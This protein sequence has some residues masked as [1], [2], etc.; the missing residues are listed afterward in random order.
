MVRLNFTNT[1]LLIGCIG[2]LITPRRNIYFFP[3]QVLP[4]SISHVYYYYFRRFIGS[5]PPGQQ[6]INHYLYTSLS[7]V[8]Q[9]SLLH[10][11]IWLTV[12]QVEALSENAIKSLFL[13]YPKAGCILLNFPPFKVLHMAYVFSLMSCVRVL[14]FF[15]PNRF[16]ALNHEKVFRVMLGGGLV[17]TVFETMRRQ[18]T[19]GVNCLQ[20]IP[21]LISS[22][23]FQPDEIPF[24]TTRTSNPSL[25]FFLILTCVN[26][27]IPSLHTSFKQVIHCV[28]CKPQVNQP[29]Q[30]FHASSQSLKQTVA[31]K[32]IKVA[33]FGG[34]IS[35]ACLL[36]LCAA[37][38]QLDDK[39]WSYRIGM[40][41]LA[42]LIVVLMPVYWLENMEEAHESMVRH[43]QHFFSPCFGR[44]DAVRSRLKRFFP[45]NRISAFADISELEET[46]PLPRRASTESSANPPIW[47]ISERGHKFNSMSQTLEF[48]SG[49]LLSA[50]QFPITDEVPGTN[51]VPDNNQVP[52]TIQVTSTNQVPSIN[53][54][55]STNQVRTADIV[56]SIIQ[57][58]YTNQFPSTNKVPSINH[59]PSTTQVQ[60]TNQVPTANQVPIINQVSSTNQASAAN[61]ARIFN[62]GSSI[63]QVS[64][65]NKVLTANQVPSITQVPSTNQ[66]LTANQVPSIYQ[67]QSAYQVQSTYLTPVQTD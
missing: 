36:A 41:R 10:A 67:V 32:L 66:V 38:F 51:Q 8:G 14:L 56:L 40:L 53:Q 22:L 6:T 20:F 23:G 30:G 28:F 29:N 7:F 21:Y 61:Q 35:A 33:T 64:A 48:S 49:R 26:F 50:N 63:T 19:S 27:S 9:A 58:P 57:V 11:Q 65:A 60:S 13:A 3:V 34:C 52:G 39:V 18:L 15:S 42:H 17:L 55:P 62:Q 46:T 1:I 2:F 5:R 45:T 25:T 31:K 12:S 24:E 47:Y 44:V 4:S 59:I 37:W 54:V 16:M 43:L